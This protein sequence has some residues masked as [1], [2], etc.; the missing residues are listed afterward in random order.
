[1]KLAQDYLSENVSGECRGGFNARL[2]GESWSKAVSGAPQGSVWAA[3]N[4]GWY[5]A[6]SMIR[7]GQIFSMIKIRGAELV[8]KC[9]ADGDKF[10]C[11]G[12]GFINLQESDDYAFGDSFDEAIIN[13]AIN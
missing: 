6:D 10:C 3:R 5:M 9:F 11:V 8:F 13:F 2:Y 4:A 1:M 7:Q 12:E